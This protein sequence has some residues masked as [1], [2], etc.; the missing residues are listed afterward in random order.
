[1]ID[2]KVLIELYINEKFSQQEIANKLNCS[3]H[4]VSYWMEKYFIKTRSISDAVYL[5]KNPKGDPFNFT[6]PKTIED[7]VLFGLGLGLYWGEGTKANKTSVRLGNTDPELILS[8]ILFLEKIFTVKRKQLHFSLQ[9][10]SDMGEGAALDF[11]TKKLKISKSQFYKT[12]ITPQRSIGTYRKKTQYG[13]LIVYF[14]NR[15]MRDNLVNLLGERK[16]LE[17]FNMPR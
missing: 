12:T 5:K 17:V 7:A 4:K 14:H 6:K 2:K 10:F 9:I 8:F 16:F 3:V 11:W 13:V 1:M 15:K